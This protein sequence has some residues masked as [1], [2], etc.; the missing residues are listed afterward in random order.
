MVIKIICCSAGCILLDEFK[1]VIMDYN[2]V[3]FMGQG[4]ADE[5]FRV[6]ALDQYGSIN[7]LSLKIYPSQTSD[8]SAYR[9]DYLDDS[10]RRFFDKI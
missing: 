6:Y 2:S 1:E 4:F 10:S 7:K 3:E 9:F 8:V 5:I